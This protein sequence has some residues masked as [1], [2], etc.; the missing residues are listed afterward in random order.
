MN[1]TK[2]LVLI[3][4]L[5]LESKILCQTWEVVKIE[6]DTSR[7]LSFTE[8]Q[9][10]VLFATQAGKQ[11]SEIQA[12]DISTI[13]Q[14]RYLGKK[15]INP[16]LKTRLV[17]AV[18]GSIVGYSVGYM[19]G[20]I[21]LWWLSY[22]DLGSLKLFGPRAENI[23]S[24]QQLI[25]DLALKISMLIGIF[26]G[27]DWKTEFIQEE[28]NYDLVSFSDVERKKYIQSIIWPNRS[29]AI[30]EILDRKV[31]SLKVLINKN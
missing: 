5:F 17:G 27:Y 13:D 12:F 22:E 28:K 29:K 6:G 20:N 1:P 30:K 14:L 7:N 15:K 11:A 24:G 26:G 31:R 23:N 4:L 8:M 10:E 21:I 18:G 2:I 16:P 9:G 19:M 3:S 25:A